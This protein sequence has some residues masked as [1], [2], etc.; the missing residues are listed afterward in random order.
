MI[1][2]RQAL[3][4]G[5]ELWIV[6]ARTG[7][8]SKLEVP[9]PWQNYP[10]YCPCCE[11][12]LKQIGKTGCRCCPIVWYDRERGLNQGSSAHL[13]CEHGSPYQA[14]LDAKNVKHLKFWAQ[15]VVDLHKKALETLTG[16]IVGAIL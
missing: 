10:Y 7:K 11:Y 6:L 2:K 8:R 4:E 15:E 12:V 3:E 13:C 14:W 9:G 16:Q 5:I 1:T